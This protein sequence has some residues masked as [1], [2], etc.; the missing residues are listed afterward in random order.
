MS[1]ERDWMSCL[2]G[3]MRSEECDMSTFISK[4]S[5]GVSFL[6]ISAFLRLFELS[7]RALFAVMIDAL[8]LLSFFL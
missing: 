4:R 7:L 3:G 6:L 8:V 2:E 1:V 5:G